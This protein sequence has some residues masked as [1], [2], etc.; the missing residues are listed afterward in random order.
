LRAINRVRCFSGRYLNIS[1]LRHMPTL[2]RIYVK[3]YIC[4][5]LPLQ[6]ATKFAQY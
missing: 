6:N 3:K 1:A 2:T 5:E 4:R